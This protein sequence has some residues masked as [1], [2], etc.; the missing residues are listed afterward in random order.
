[1]NSKTLL[2][3]KEKKAISVKRVFQKGIP[4]ES[5]FFKV[6]IEKGEKAHGSFAVVVGRKFG[7]AV[8]RNRMKRVYREILRSN[9]DLFQDKNVVILPRNA[10]KKASFF[11]LNDKVRESLSVLD[12][13]YRC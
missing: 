5:P 3:K 13:G 9:S 8:E 1:M 6:I 12:Q 10:S 4:L 2:K 7:K 11:Q